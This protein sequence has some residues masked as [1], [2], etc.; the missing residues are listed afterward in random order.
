MTLR[1]KQVG[2]ETVFTP[3][4]LNSELASYLA[5]TIRAHLGGPGN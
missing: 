3:I 5:K 2:T 1:L 4:F